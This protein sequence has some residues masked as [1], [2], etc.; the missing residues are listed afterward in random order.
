MIRH[1]GP[2]LILTASVVGSGE[3]IAT[4]SLGAKAGFVALWL[5]LVSCVIKVA[6]QLII[7]RYAIFSGETT[8]QFMNELP[9]PRVRASWFIWCHFLM[10]MMINFQQGAMLGGVGQVLNIVVPQ[11]SVAVWALIAALVTILL[12]RSGKYRLIE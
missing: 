8:L 9:G 12:L 10:L 6:V 3:L 1:F 5:I 7:G 4:T 2:G 11:L